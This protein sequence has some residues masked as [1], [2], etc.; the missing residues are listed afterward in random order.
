MFR[1]CLIVALLGGTGCGPIEYITT[2]T[3]QARRAVALAERARAPELAPYEYTLAVENLMK[4]RELG[5]ASR[6]QDS[7]TCG[8]NAVKFGR[9]AEGLALQKAA[10]PREGRR[11]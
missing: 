5:S 8:L 7:L 6:W 1:A 2:V 4:A 10:R 3:L 11:E 9:E